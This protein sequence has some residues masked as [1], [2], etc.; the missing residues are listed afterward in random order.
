MRLPQVS[1]N[2]AVVTGP[3]SVDVGHREGGRRDPVRGQGLPVRPDSRVIGGLQDELDAVGLPRRHDSQPAVLAERHLGLLHEAEHLG[4][5]LQRLVLV[6]DVDAGQGDSH[7]L[8]LGLRAGPPVS[9][10]RQRGAVERV[11]LVAAL[12]PGHDQARGLEHVKVLR[13]GLPG[14]GQAMTGGQPGAD[15]EQRLV[16]ALGQLVKDP[17]PGQVGQG[18][19]DVGHRAIIGK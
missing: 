8:L 16:A 19:E 3:I 11:V 15:L 2:T 17:A 18:L 10:A 4:V 5:E 14:G 1:S 9:D 6:I 12:A 7:G 13:D